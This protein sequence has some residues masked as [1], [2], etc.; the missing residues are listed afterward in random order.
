LEGH[1]MSSNEKGVIRQ[2]FKKKRVILRYF[3]Q[4]VLFQDPSLIHE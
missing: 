3:Q 2:F 1:W 4:C